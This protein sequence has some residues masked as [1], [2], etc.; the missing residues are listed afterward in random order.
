M[1]T[2][3]QLRHSEQALIKFRQDDALSEILDEYAELIRDY[4]KLKTEYEEARESRERYKKLSKGQDLGQYV[5]VLIDGD[6]D[7]YHF[8]DDFVR[9][10]AEDGGGNAARALNEAVKAK[11]EAKNLEHCQILI[12]I[13]AN[14]A[15]LSKTL[16]RAGL[17]GPEKR[18]LTPFIAD[19]NRS[20][21]YCDFVDAG[22][23]KESADFKLRDQL[24]HHI[25]NVQVIVKGLL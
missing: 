22:E 11:L 9:K 21:G 5:I 19:F 10:G 16:S 25:S 24:R 4:N 8:Q 1:L 6:G 20:F 13:Y 14:V 23:L 15:G 7:G 18:S 17:C 3:D 2:E 12:R